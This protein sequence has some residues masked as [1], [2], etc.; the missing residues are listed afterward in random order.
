MSL[1]NEGGPP[2][3][4]RHRLEQF[5]RFSEEHRNDSNESV[6]ESTGENS[7]GEDEYLPSI[8]DFLPSPPRPPSPMA[9][10]PA[11]D[12]L[13]PALILLA[14]CFVVSS[15]RWS[16]A[17]TSI[18]GTEASYETV[19]IKHQWWRLATALLTHADMGHLLSNT[20]LFLIFGWYLRDFFG[21]RIFP[22]ISL[23]IGIFANALTL[24]FY[25]K[26]T[27]LLGAS[28]M[29]Y[30]MVALWLVFYVHFETSYTHAQRILRA[31]GVSL[32]LLFPTTFHSD[33]SYLCHGLG[34]LLGSLFGLI[35]KPFVKVI[36]S[37]NN[38]TV[39]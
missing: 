10:Y 1:E 21:L 36:Q 14:L 29:L 28:G 20:P 22:G 6:L 38:D 3:F 18:G 32:L 9:R 2:N 24:L 27:S 39:V 11:L 25:P 26:E 5:K 13:K 4:R 8:D 23:I 19:W 33:T 16:Q 7:S 34:F 37:L 31:L 30:G 17:W 12:S 15:A 35:L